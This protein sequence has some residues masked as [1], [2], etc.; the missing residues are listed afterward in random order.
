MR[1][2]V[3]PKLPWNIKNRL[4]DMLNRTELNGY[5]PSK[6]AI[7]RKIQELQQEFQSS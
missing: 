1:I 3:I 5:T 4:T 6:E 7:L 2:C